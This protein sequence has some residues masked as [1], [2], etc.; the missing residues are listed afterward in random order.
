VWKC[1]AYAGASQQDCDSEAAATVFNYPPATHN[2]TSCSSSD[3]IENHH[4]LN[5]HHHHHHHQQQGELTGKMS[6]LS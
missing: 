1:L 6:T 4:Q 5:S 3:V 2:S